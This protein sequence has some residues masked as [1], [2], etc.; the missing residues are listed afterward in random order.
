[1]FKARK[2]WKLKKIVVTK[3]VWNGD[4]YNI[5]NKKLKNGGTLKL[6][7]GD[8]VWVTIYMYN[9]KTGLTEGCELTLDRDVD[10]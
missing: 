6:K 9:K 8:Y 5:S 3:A 1:M 7:E 2:G 10:Y 4:D